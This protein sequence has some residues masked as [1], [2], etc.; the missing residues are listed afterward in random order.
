MLPEDSAAR[1]AA[2]L[3]AVAKVQ[4]GRVDDHFEMVKPGDKPTPYS[5][6][7]FRDAAIQWLIQTDQ[8]SIFILYAVICL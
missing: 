5:D 6:S 4:Q 3:E 2:S 7:T 8:V 1:K